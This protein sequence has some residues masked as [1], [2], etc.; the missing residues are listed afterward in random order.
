MRS[1]REAHS[2][3]NAFSSGEECEGPSDGVTTHNTN[4]SEVGGGTIGV[5]LYMGSMLNVEQVI[6]PAMFLDL[7]TSELFLSDLNFFFVIIGIIF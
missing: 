3:R 5:G 1:S 6:L 4:C 7:D 2:R